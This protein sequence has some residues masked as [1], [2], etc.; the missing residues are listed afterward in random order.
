MTCAKCGLLVLQAQQFGPSSR[1]TSNLVWLEKDDNPVC[2]DLEDI[3]GG[4]R[5][6]S[7]A[8]LAMLN[9]GGDCTKHATYTKEK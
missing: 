8:G 2:D 1:M 5:A 7:F 9:V 4:M 3:G 6:R